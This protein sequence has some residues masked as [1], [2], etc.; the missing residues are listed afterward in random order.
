VHFLSARKFAAGDLDGNGQDEIMIDFGGGAGIWVF[1]NNSDWTRLDTRSATGIQ[2]GDLD[3][4]G[5]DEIVISFVPAQEVSCGDGQDDDAD[6]TID[7]DDS[8]C[9]DD[10]A[11]EACES[12][13]TPDPVEP[14][15]LPSESPAG[16][17]KQTTVGEF[18]DDYLF[19]NE[20]Y[21]KVGIRREWGGAIVFYGVAGGANTIDANDVG[22]EV[23]VALYDPDRMFQNCA[24][25][26][27]CA[28]SDGTECP[29]SITYLGWNPVQGGN[30]C[31]IGSGVVDVTYSDGVLSATTD[32]LFWNPN[33]DRTDC[34]DEACDETS[35]RERRSDVR[36][37]QSLK[38]IKRHILELDYTVSNLGDVD[39]AAM[40]QEMPTVY[41]ARS[42]NGL[43]LW[44]VFNSEGVET[45]VAGSSGTAYKDIDSPGGWVTMQDSAL[46]LGVGLYME[47]KLS[48]F[49]SWQSH[50]DFWSNFRPSFVFGIPANGTIRARSYLLIGSLGTIQS[51][52]AWL[53]AHLPPFGHLDTPASDAT[54]TGTVDFSG[55]ALDNNAVTAIE[56]VIDGD[57]TILATYGN[58]RPDVCEVWPGYAG[59]PAVG[60]AAS[61]DTATLSAC[62]HLVEVRAKDAHGNE[63]TIA[64]RRVSVVRQ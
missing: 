41:T 10:T 6:G 33:W 4:N 55:W 60:F 49:G 14:S 37:V 34:S 57:V 48:A 47:N 61:L 8:D 59:C 30:R 54:L 20:D 52:A 53:D 13:P 15:P 56:I 45:I 21:I 44:R 9:A 39:H 5:Q 38:F 64:A 1:A 27:S 32:P 43:N 26:A 19:D 17:W 24:W 29:L 50:S 58:D 16:Q 51:E 23:Q 40:S 25:D 42:R 63:K 7:C 36:L 11:C 35:L 31:N 12:V 18:H 46:G 62:Q 3:R 22:R 28:S 2:T